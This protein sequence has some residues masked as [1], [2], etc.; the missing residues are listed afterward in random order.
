MTGITYR[1]ATAAD[2]DLLVDLR[3]QFIQLAEDHP[4][5][6]FIRNNCYSFFR[7]SYAENTCCV[8]LAQEDQRV[9]GTAIVFYYD[10]VPTLRNPAGKNAYITSM[11]VEPEYRRRGIATAIVNQIV[12]DALSRDCVNIMLTATEMGRPVYEQ[13]GFVSTTNGMIYDLSYQRSRHR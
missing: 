9:V 7:K 5:Y 1:K 4:Q 8:I 3:L 13:N 10:S 11:Y 2:I 12:D 6:S